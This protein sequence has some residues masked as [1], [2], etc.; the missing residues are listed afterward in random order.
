MQLIYLVVTNCKSI[1]FQHSNSS[2]NSQ[3]SFYHIALHSSQ[4]FHIKT[5]LTYDFN[6]F[7][8]M[9]RKYA[10]VPYGV[11]PI[12]LHILTN[13]GLLNRTKGN[14]DHLSSKKKKQSY[15]ID[16]PKLLHICYMSYLL[17]LSNVSSSLNNLAKPK[18]SSLETSAPVLTCMRIPSGS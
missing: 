11:I 1:W 13:R 15:W 12:Y 9:K 14:I 17:I 7:R 5:D 18:I 16:W 2:Y 6:L 8:S 4:W 3:L 10:S